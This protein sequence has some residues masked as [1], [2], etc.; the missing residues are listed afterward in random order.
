[1][2]HE[3][4]RRADG[5]FAMAYIGETPWHRHGQALE[6][7]ASIETWIQAAG[8]DWQAIAAPVTYTDAHGVA[9]VFEEKKILFR[10]DTG[11]PLSVVGEGFQVVQPREV[12][13]WFRTLTENEGWHLHTAGVL[14]D[15]RRVWAMASREGAADIVKGDTV[16]E[17]LLLAT[18][19]DGTLATHAGLTSIRVVCANTLGFALAD[20]LKGAKGKGAARVSHRSEFDGEAIKRAI[21][22]AGESFAAHV[23]TARTLAETPCDMEEARAIL[24]R[25]FGD[26]I[27]AKAKAEAPAAVAGDGFAAL[28][29]LAAPAAVDASDTL[30]GLLARP[31]V[32]ADARTLEA[33]ADIARMLAKGDEREQKSVARCLALFAGE[34]RGATMPGVAGTRWGLL[35][36]VTEHIDHEQGRDGTRLEAAW[37]GRGADF[38]AEALDLLT[39]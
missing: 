9:R 30:A 28:R 36:A 31:H 3:L 7:G 16:T 4:A 13:E 14:R 2:A 37:F 32:P 34:G 25:L 8:F 24:R 10:S 18:G 6:K 19:L 33:R 20:G 22:V 11:A 35:N 5:R 1:M 15:G 29:S 39:A 12:I 26:P 23:E 17:N 21:G 38:K 27:K